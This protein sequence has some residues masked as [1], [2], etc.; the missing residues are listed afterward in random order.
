MAALISLI[1]LCIA[2]TLQF[3]FPFVES[4]NGCV[5]ADLIHRDSPLSPLYRPSET[6]SER[7]HK[8]YLRSISR[9]NNHFNTKAA[10]PEALQAPMVSSGGE[11]FI[12]ISIGTPG[13]ELI[14]IADTASDLTWIQ[15]KPCYKC[16]KQNPPIFDPKQ[17]STSENVTC[18]SESCLRLEKDKRCETNGNTCQFYYSY[19]D[20]SYT[21]GNVGTE[22]FVI[23]SKTSP[24]QSTFPNI[25]YGCGNNNTGT[26]DEVGSGIVGLGG[27]PL[28]LISQITKSIGGKFSYCLVPTSSQGNA[29][30][31]INFGEIGLVPGTSKVVTVDLVDKQPSTYYHVTLEAISV[32]NKRVKYF[33]S[34]ATDGEEG[35]MIIDSGTTFTFLDPQFYEKFAAVLE[36]QVGSKRV[37]DPRGYASACFKVGKESDLPIITFHFAGAADLKLNTVNA[38]ARLEEENLMCVNMLPVDPIGVFGNLSQMDFLLQFDLVKRKVSFIPTD[39]A[40]Y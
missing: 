15:C 3:V 37:D 1:A 36:R 21:T 22:I 39:C 28:S 6:N 7:F 17:S 29:T 30:S 12:N 20:G 11:Y 27:G 10:S 23:S 40:K 38:F 18:Q 8:A 9:L 2:T 5:T 24:D 13:V 34:N 26:F 33:T 16:Y 14:G 19:A 31:K 35:N 32:G 4:N 25:V